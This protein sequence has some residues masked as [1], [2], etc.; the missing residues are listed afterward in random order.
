MESGS[1][2]SDVPNPDE[3]CLVCGETR[4]NHGD[5]NHRFNAVD[6]QLIPITP[7][8]KRRQTPPT[9]RTALGNGASPD[10]PEARALATLVDILAQKDLLTTKEIIRIFSGQG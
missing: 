4:E 9:E 8:P 6:D 2:M 10:N 5:K 3:V 7:G 1:K